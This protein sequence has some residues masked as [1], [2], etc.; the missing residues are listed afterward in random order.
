[1]IV[2][3]AEKPDQARKLASPFPHTKGN[4]F[5]SI[6]SCKEF[7]NGATVTWAIGHLV[8]LKEPEEYRPEW[9]KWDLATLPIIPGQ[10]EYKVSKDKAKQFQT[11][12]KL[13]KEADE[14]IIATDPAREG[15]N[16][17]RLLILMAGCSKKRIKRFWTSSL[18]ENAI[19]KGFAELKDGKE[20]I[21]LFHEAQAR[22]IADW[23]VGM[24]ASR[25]YTLLLQ[26]KGIRDVFSVG[27]V[28]TPVLKLIYDRQKEIEHFQPEPFY[29][30]EG[31]FTVKN[32]TYRGKLNKRFSSPDE[33][34][35]A[36][37]PD[38]TKE[39]QTYQAVI[40]S[41]RISEKRTPAPKLHSLSTLQSKL[42]RTKKFSPTK[43]LELVQ[44]LYEKGYV[45]YP[46][47]DSQ[48]ITEEEYTYLQK[49]VDQYQQCLGIHV[50]IRSLQPS[51]RYVN[52]EK[53]SD[54]Y[55]IIPTEKVPDTKAFETFSS[56]E[57]EVY[58]EILK[59][60][61]AMFMTDYVYDETVIITSVGKQEFVT[62]GR[63]EKEMGW[64][65]LY[66]NEK[67]EESEGEQVAI[68]PE[69]KEGESAK[70]DISVK[71]G[72][73]QPP[74]PYTQGQ[75]ITLMKTAGK[76]VEDREMKEALNQVE[77]LG[78]EATRAAIIDTLIQ[79]RLIEVKKN[80]VFVTKKGEILCEA[81]KGTILSKPE[82][83]AKWELFLQEI[84]KGNR[85]K[86]VFIEQAK[87]LCY[88]LIQQASQDVERID[89]KQALEEI[90]KENTIA[91][92]P[93]CQKGYIVDRK[94]FYGCT[95]YANGCKQTFPKSILGK[96]ITKTHVKQLC[97]KGK[98]NKI[99]G[100]KGKKTFDAYLTLQ[101]GEIQFTFQ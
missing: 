27:R 34:Y 15:E 12:K 10:F 90:K 6:Q 29:E 28:Q 37:R 81:V 23:L 56:D 85:S 94:T 72:M 101:K 55:A 61:L 32:G 71:Q 17:A 80:Q 47:T 46:R 52:P 50:P 51:K 59:S 82:M 19:R 30:L 45:S 43:V 96:N 66:Q 33:L 16:I 21:H 93:R 91:P 44:S 73:T 4:G 41:V 86:E 49:H 70:A 39:Q 18:T 92:C 48:Y 35:E 24:N 31:Q 67:D 62:K 3:L 22:Q 2:I 53:V 84:G 25:L 40:K 63:T 26:Q 77:G 83:T 14:I 58:Y 99:K 38:I 68:L 13:L 88:A 64:K 100:F 97:E 36:V 95:E 1:M 78:T 9:K 65:A 20:T 87:K 60:A 57:K 79:R 54:H 5:L 98:T 89:A 76:Y 8:E 69:V 7:P 11:V 74:K 75:L 42:N